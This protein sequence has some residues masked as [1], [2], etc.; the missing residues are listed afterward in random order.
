MRQKFKHIMKLLHYKVKL[1]EIASLTLDPTILYT[2]STWPPLF[3]SGTK[4]QITSNF[5]VE[6]NADAQHMLLIGSW[7]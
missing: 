3:A 6:R 7:L 4:K 2:I 5:P 1:V